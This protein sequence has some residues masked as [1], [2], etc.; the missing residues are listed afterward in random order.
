MRVCSW[1]HW[2]YVER[3]KGSKAVGFREWKQMFPLGMRSVEDGIT[4]IGLGKKAVMGVFLR[5]RGTKGRHFCIPST[6]GPL[7]N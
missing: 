7:K 3:D 5:D 2:Q 6:A 1:E 4:R